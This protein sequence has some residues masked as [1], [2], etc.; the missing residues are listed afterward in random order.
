M[1]CW[2][3]DER[4]WQRHHRLRRGRAVVGG[5]RRREIGVEVDLATV[6]PM[7][8]CSLEIW[9]SEAQSAWLAVPP[10][11]RERLE[12]I[13]AL[14]GGDT[15]SALR[16][17]GRLSLTYEQRSGLSFHVVL[18][19]RPA[20][21][22][23]ARRV[24]DARVGR[25]MAHAE[26]RSRMPRW[27]CWP[28]PTCAVKGRRDATTTRPCHADRSVGVRAD[29]PQTRPCSPLE[30]RDAGSAS[31][32]QRFNPRLRQARSPRHGGERHRRGGAQWCLCADPSASPS[33]TTFASNLPCP[34][35][36]GARLRAAMTALHYGTPYIRQGQPQQRVPDTVT[37]KQA[38]PPIA[39][40][41][42]AL[43]PTPSAASP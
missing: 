21:P 9:L 7:P 34:T 11:H 22:T 37:G 8:A 33:S 32:W 30:V 13:C 20:T 3:R 2:R 28:T 16:D 18:A 1:P 39:H 24:A 40:L 25:P 26:S 27:R 42:A 35:A 4:L 15:S 43:C 41:G 38:I 5:E 12:D 36:P 17:S 6:P 10:A 29:G 19:R 14:Y 23:V 31:P